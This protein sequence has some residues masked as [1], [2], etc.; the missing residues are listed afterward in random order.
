MAQKALD[1]WLPLERLVGSLGHLQGPEPEAKH[2]YT[3]LAPGRP[4]RAIGISPG[5]HFLEQSSPDVTNVAVVASLA[6]HY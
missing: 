1:S 4:L 3:T 5:L 6:T 2:R